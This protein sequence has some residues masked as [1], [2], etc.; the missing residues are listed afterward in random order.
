LNIKAE[1]IE[2]GFTTKCIA[3]A[4]IHLVVEKNYIRETGAQN[5][6]MKIEALPMEDPALLR[7]FC[8][9]EY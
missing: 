1:G 4:S 2:I 5:I 9:D 8:L 6:A 7:I 3:R